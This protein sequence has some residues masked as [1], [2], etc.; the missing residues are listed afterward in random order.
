[1]QHMVVLE[2]VPSGVTSFGCSLVYKYILFSNLCRYKYLYTFIFLMKC[3][4][5]LFM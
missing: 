3:F 4:I 2:K 5:I 1:M